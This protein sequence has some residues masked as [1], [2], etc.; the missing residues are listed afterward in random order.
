MKPAAGLAGGELLAELNAAH[1]A[2]AA[3]EYADGLSAWRAAVTAADERLTEVQAEMA[4][5]VKEALD[6]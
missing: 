2:R 1:A 4:K 3:A 5:R 6:G